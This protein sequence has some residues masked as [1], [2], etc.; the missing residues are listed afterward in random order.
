MLKEKILNVLKK[1]NQPFHF[2]NLF[3]KVKD[4]DLKVS[5]YK[6]VLKELKE[7][8]IITVDKKEFIS[9]KEK[10]DTKKYQLSID[11]IKETYLGKCFLHVDHFIVKVSKINK[12][13]KIV[14]PDFEVYEGAVVSI[15]VIKDKC[16]IKNNL[17]MCEITSIVGDGNVPLLET[18]IAIENHELPNKF[19]E[20]VLK[21]LD[22]INQTIDSSEIKVRQDLRS[23]PFVTIDGDDSRDF[24]DAVFC[25]PFNE[26]WNLYVA[27]ADVSH[28]VRPTTCLDKEAYRRGTSVYFPSEVIPML[29]F[30]LSN[31]LCS[32][33]PEEDR[34]ALTVKISINKH[35]SIKKYE[36]MNSII[37]SKARLTYSYVGKIMENKSYTNDA[38]GLNLQHLV[39]VY[40]ALRTSREN[41]GA[42]DFERKEVKI[43]FKEDK[44]ISDVLPYE[45]NEAY[46]VIEECMLAANVCAAKLLQQ[47]N[48]PTLYRVHEGPKDERLSSLKD[49]LNSV[50]LR[51][52]GA[53]D[54]KVKPQH[55]KRLLELSRDRHDYE[56]IQ[57]TVLRSMAQAKYQPENNGH[58]GL[59]YESYLHFTSPIRRY[60]DLIVHRAIKSLIFDKKTVDNVIKQESEDSYPYTYTLEEMGVIG[61]H[62]SMTERRA[63]DA[64]RDVYD[65]LKCHFLQ[66]HMQEDFEGKVS[67][68]TKSALYIELDK[69]LME[70]VVY[71]EDMSDFFIYFPERAMIKGKRSKKTYQLGDKVVVRIA[72]INY[73]NKKVIF[74]IVD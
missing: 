36:F 24:D 54:E 12:A 42:L 31:G 59:A 28:Y 14:N 38:V 4:K 62:C 71:Y 30:L 43:L 5:A 21:E 74:H 66:G 29:P 64:S 73:E 47:N 72:K 56:L 19:N 46:K 58:F 25:E 61:D 44:S 15:K 48:V 60:P 27:I 7:K 11:D 49:F 70:G 41:R 68:L 22:N 55:Y 57:L 8:N 52:R 1:S 67:F 63:D 69:F 13:F 40:K 3:D 16:D 18:E 26:G 65:A 37:K 50:G 6:K 33:N 51:L 23:I 9:L 45:R 20:D 39:E 17:F 32:L 34:L 2:F 10:E 53:D 35:G